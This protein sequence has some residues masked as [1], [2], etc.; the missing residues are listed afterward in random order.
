VKSVDERFWEVVVVN[1]KN[2]RFELSP[3]K[4]YQIKLMNKSIDYCFIGSP[5]IS[6]RVWLE[7]NFCR[8]LPAPAPKY[9]KF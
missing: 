7:I 1:T 2:G 8:T 9:R 4:L 5:I 6:T 3:R